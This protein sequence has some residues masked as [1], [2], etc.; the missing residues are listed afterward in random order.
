MKEDSVIVSA[1]HTSAHNGVT[2]VYLQQLVNGLQVFNGVAN[3]NVDRSG[4]IISVGNSFFTKK[5]PA[6]ASV[7]K[8]SASQAVLSLAKLLNLD[9]EESALHEAAESDLSS[10]IASVEV[11]GAA[12][13][14]KPISATLKYIQVNGG[15]SLSLVWSLETDMKDNM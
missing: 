4:V 11:S 1:S 5:I 13:A 7:P 8:F 12:W 2:H 10:G 15:S 9:T 14:L 6:P 3:V